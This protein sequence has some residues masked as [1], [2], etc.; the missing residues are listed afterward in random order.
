M[1]EDEYFRSNYD[2]RSMLRVL[3]NSDFFKNARFAK[4]KSPVETVVGTTRLVGDFTFPKPG[5]NALVAEYALHGAGPAE[6]AHGGRL[7]YGQGVDRQ[8][9]PGR[10]HQLHRRPGG[11]Y[12]P[13]GVRPSSTGCALRGRRCRQSAWWMAVSSCWGVMNWRR[14]THSDAGDAGSEWWRDCA[15]AQKTSPSEWP[16]CSSR[17]SRPQNIFSPKGGRST[18]G[19]EYQRPC[20]GGPPVVRGQRRA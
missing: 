12:Q 18:Y 15:P 2:I 9:H 5:F 11:Q 10:A 14:E 20:A 4:V 6:P 17:S 13:P 1:L 19:I 8:R 3:F 16:R 7:A